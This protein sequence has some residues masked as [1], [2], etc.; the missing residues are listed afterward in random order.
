M[1][2]IAIELQAPDIRP[3]RASNTG[4][5]FIHSFDSGKPGPHVLVNALTHGNEI[6][7]AIVVDRLL[8]R[9][10]RPVR[11]R[12]T[13]AFANVEA[14][15]RF[16]PANPYAT[17][18]VDEDFNRVW[19]PA[20]LDGPRRSVELDRAR[21]LRPFIDAADYLLDIHSMLEP[22]PP[23]MICGPLEKG[24]RFAFDVGVPRNIV[25]DTGHSN[26]TRM[27]D[28][29]GFGDPASPKNALLVECG[30]HWERSSERVAWQTLWRFLRTLGV[31]EPEAAVRE[32]EPAQA[33]QRLIR[34]TEAVIANSPAFR[35]AR[36]FTGLDVVPHR[37]DVIAWDG[38]QPVRAPYDNCVLVMP[39]PNNV[40]TGLTAVRLGR[41]E[42]R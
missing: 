18:F 37:G 28:Y 17:R 30:Q 2:P 31:A 29:G 39:V 35:F 22:S 4:T 41:E 3:H 19:T 33:P 40:K 7:G 13:L 15:L 14:F 20:T 12:L 23:V 36:S 9:G 32:I 27:R 38:D 25:S 21:A 24:I 5:D 16:D 11:G 42:T 26:G 10:L 8:R 1:P 34:V 6:C